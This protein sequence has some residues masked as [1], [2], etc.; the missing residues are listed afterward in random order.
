MPWTIHQYATA[1]DT[2]IRRIQVAEDQAKTLLH[3]GHPSAAQQVYDR[4]A[5]YE[6][7][8]D[9]LE[10]QWD[11]QQARHAARQIRRTGYAFE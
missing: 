5:V 11:T 7:A 9:R 1:R 8:L 10:L 2:L 6:A 4:I 3:R